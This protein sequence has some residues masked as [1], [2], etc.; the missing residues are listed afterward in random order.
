MVVHHFDSLHHTDLQ[1]EVVSASV[2]V[3]LL[4]PLVEDLELPDLIVN[5]PDLPHGLA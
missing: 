5:Q 2:L 1:S 4:R 3:G